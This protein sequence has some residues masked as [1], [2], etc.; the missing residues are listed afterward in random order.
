MAYIGID[1]GKHGAIVR[2]TSRGKVTPWVMPLR[3]DNSIDLDEL[4]SI[5]SKFGKRDRVALELIHSIYGTGKGSMFTMGRGLGNIEAAL[6]CNNVPFTYVRPADWQARIWEDGDVVKKKSK[7]GK[8]RVN[9]TKTTSL[10]AAIRLFP[11]LDLRYGS[12][13]TL[14][15]GRERV[16][17]HDG[18][19]DALL[20]AQ[21]ARKWIK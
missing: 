17:A 9:D 20:I 3:G 12:N 13:E 21:Y 16:L 2:I 10:R 14:Y 19:V 4:C 1:P 11:G 5:I 8:R 7:S 18:I 6:H 15:K